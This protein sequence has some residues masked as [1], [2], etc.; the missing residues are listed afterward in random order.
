MRCE[1]SLSRGGAGHHEHVQWGANPCDRWQ[2]VLDTDEQ[3]F[4]SFAPRNLKR[5]LAKS[6]ELVRASVSSFHGLDV[7][8]V[9]KLAAAL[10]MV[11]CLLG[12]I[13]VPQNA[14]LTDAESTL[15]GACR[16]PLLLR[17]GRP[18]APQRLRRAQAGRSAGRG[19]R[20]SSACRRG[21][22]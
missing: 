6:A 2:L 8:P 15:C 20:T 22:T 12:T 3:L 16:A 10:T 11:G 14:L 17:S 4:A 13:V 7:A 5:A 21:S 1:R 19:R 18:A 9:L